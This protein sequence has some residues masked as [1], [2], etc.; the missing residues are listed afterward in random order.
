MKIKP[1]GVTDDS[2]AEHNDESNK[3]DPKFKMMIM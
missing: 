2:F 1:I 3:K